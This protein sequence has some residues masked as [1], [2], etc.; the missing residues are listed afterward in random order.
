VDKEHIV[1]A[2][3]IIRNFFADNQEKLRPI[4][5]KLEEL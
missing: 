4:K 2:M 3:E 1:K 5:D